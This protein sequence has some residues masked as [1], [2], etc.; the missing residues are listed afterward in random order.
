MARAGIQRSDADAGPFPLGEVLRGADLLGRA[1]HVQLRDSAGQPFCPLQ[2]ASG[3]RPVELHLIRLCRDA[4]FLVSDAIQRRIAL[5]WRQTPPLPLRR[6]EACHLRNG[7]RDPSLGSTCA[8]VRV[9]AISWLCASAAASRSRSRT[10]G[11]SPR[12]ARNLVMASSTPP[13]PSRTRPSGGGLEG[14]T[15]PAKTRRT[16][17]T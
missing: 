13:R 15:T 16:A 7:V 12:D 6:D 14:G 8:N 3:Q 4:D 1:G 5:Q 11:G 2:G 9:R 17:A 10:S